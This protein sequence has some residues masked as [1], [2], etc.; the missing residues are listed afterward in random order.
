MYGPRQDPYGEA[1][2]VSIFSNKYLN[3][4]RPVI[5]GNGEQT[6]DYIYV[7]DVISAL[8]ESSKIAGCYDFIVKKKDGF[9]S[10]ISGDDGE[11]TP[12][13]LQKISNAR[14]FY[15]DPKIIILDEPSSMSETVY[16][17]RLINYLNK[18][19]SK[20]IIILT[21]HQPEYSDIADQIMVLKDGKVLQFGNKKE[22]LSKILRKPGN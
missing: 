17:L 8:I 19:K 10:K 7:Q 1:G 5:Y 6:R 2:V 21:S 12:G 14:A 3:G 15:G 20:K 13:Q 11:Y 4:E 9:N 18:V 16:A 22:V